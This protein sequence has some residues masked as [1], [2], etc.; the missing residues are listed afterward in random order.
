MFILERCSKLLQRFFLGLISC[1][2]LGSSMAERAEAQPKGIL[3]QEAPNWNVH[4]WINVDKDEPEPEITDYSGKVLY[5]YFFQA[6]CPGCHRHGF[7]TLQKMAAKYKQ[8]TS[9][10][11]IAIQSVFEGFSANTFARAGEVAQQYKLTFPVGHS[12]NNGVR[13]PLL[14]SYRSGGTPWTIIVD[15][16]GVVRYN[17]FHIEVA[18]ASTLIQKLKNNK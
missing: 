4:Q 6:W 14:K 10:A 13:S 11:F 1:L 16:D 8:D 7:P 18:T 9:V 12:G 15:R 17:D 5:L 3:N 2:L